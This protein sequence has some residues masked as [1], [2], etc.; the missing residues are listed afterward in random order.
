MPCGVCTFAH[1]CV[2][3][4][5]H[6]CVCTHVRA[7]ACVYM[8]KRELQRQREAMKVSGRLDSIRLID[9]AVVTRLCTSYLPF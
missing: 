1:V 9:D 2:C 7:C 3:M 5:V 4:C 6:E 8:G